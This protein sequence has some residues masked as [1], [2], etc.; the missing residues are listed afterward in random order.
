MFSC[1]GRGVAL[2]GESDHDS[3]LFAEHLPEVPLGGFFGN[4]EIGP[5]QGRTHVHAYTSSFGLFRSV[6]Q[7]RDGP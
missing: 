3:L 5:V 6:T 2:Y 4:G 7:R 1:L